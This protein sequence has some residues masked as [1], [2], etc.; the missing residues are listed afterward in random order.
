MCP[1][2][3]RPELHPRWQ[4]RHRQ[5]AKAPP[6]ARFGRQAQNVSEYRAR[7]GGSTAA[8]RRRPAP[9]APAHDNPIGAAAGLCQDV[10]PTYAT[11]ATPFWRKSMRTQFAITTAAC[12]LAVTCFAGAAGAQ[13]PAPAAQEG[14]AIGS[15]VANPTYISIPLEITV[16]RP[17]AEVW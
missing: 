10:Q 1:L 17:A 13:A 8:T 12:A 9:A 11:R 6:G 2:N 7:Q 16:N 15:A 14:A 3:E 5:S 4:L